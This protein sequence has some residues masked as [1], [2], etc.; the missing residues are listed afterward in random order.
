MTRLCLLVLLV[1]LLF[2][3]PVPNPAPKYTISGVVISEQTNQPIKHA[4]VTITQN[5]H[6]DRAASLY[7]AADGRFTFTDVPG[8]KFTM[9]AAVRGVER[10]L[11]QDGQFST[12]IVTAP[13]IDSE[14]IVFRFPITANITLKVQDEQGEPVPN[15]QVAL[16]GE[17]VNAGWQQVNIIQQSGTDNDGAARLSHIEPGARYYIAVFGRPWYSQDQ[18][19][20]MPNTN[21]SEIAA[22]DVAYPPTYYPNSQSPDGAAPIILG[23]GERATLQ[24]TLHAVPA[25]KIS[26]DGLPS[27]SEQSE[28]SRGG[29]RSFVEI[30][31]PQGVR[32]MVNA[33]ASYSNDGGLEIHGLAPGNY[34]VSLSRVGM[35][36]HFPE[37]LGSARVSASGDTHINANDLPRTSVTGKLTLEGS[38]NPGGLAVWLMQPTTGHTAM[39]RAAHDGAFEC[40]EGRG[41]GEVVQ[42]GR[43]EIRLAN[44]TEFYIKSVSAQGAHYAGGLLDV[45]EGASIALA[46]V[47][48]KGST[49]LDGIALRNGKPLA[50]AM[51]LLVPRD[52][53]S[54]ADIPRDQSDSD[55]TFTLPNVHLGPYYLLAIDNGRNLVYHDPKVIAPYLANAQKITIPLAREE[56]VSV[57]VQP[58]VP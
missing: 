18:M 25:I 12:G 57:T 53:G 31:G 56:R 33:G 13:G 48:A 23:P 5:D 39:C 6:P 17:R 19:S 15:A 55:G 3:A 10:L 8:G 20:G 58:R 40:R 32:F 24:M 54:A 37:A 2:A 45:R 14:H 34:I 44:S 50:G 43:Y 29:V 28:Q 9:Q 51:V 26:V 46:V 36:R 4:L 38:G 22:L 35:R 27:A 41:M 21:Q 49:K 11:N 7:T 30:V 47:A 42:P 1:G 52:A 16:F